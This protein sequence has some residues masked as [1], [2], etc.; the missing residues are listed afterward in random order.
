MK[1]DE[2]GT[3]GRQPQT[4]ESPGPPETGVRKD[5]SPES[6]EGAI[7]DARPPERGRIRTAALSP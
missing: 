7:L 2:G 5:P 3:G 1:G 6:L 4:K